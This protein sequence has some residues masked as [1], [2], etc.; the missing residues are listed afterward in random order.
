MLRKFQILMNSSEKQFQVAV[1]LSFA[2][3][4]F[5]DR[6]FI[7]KQLQDLV[8]CEILYIG[9]YEHEIIR[10]GSCLQI[11]KCCHLFNFDLYKYTG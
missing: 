3:H 2:Q 9:D 11:L 1:I 8:I 6:T 4:S 10:L 7:L 5:I